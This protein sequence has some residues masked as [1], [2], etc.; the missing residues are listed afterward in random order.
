MYIIQVNIQKSIIKRNITYIVINEY[1]SKYL[2]EN[3]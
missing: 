3:Y 1:I 2:K